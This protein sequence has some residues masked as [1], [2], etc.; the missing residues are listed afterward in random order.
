MRKKYCLQYF[1]AISSQISGIFL[2]GFTFSTV[3]TNGNCKMPCSGI[4]GYEKLCS[5]FALCT[6]LPPPQFGQ[7]AFATQSP[8]T[9]PNRQLPG[10]LDETPQI[11]AQKG[12]K[13]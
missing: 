9:C 4:L 3:S 7:G 5:G 10:T 1:L 8:I 2:T 11:F 6:V 13:V 12:Q